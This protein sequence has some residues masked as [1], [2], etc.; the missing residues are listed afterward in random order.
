MNSSTTASWNRLLV[1]GVFRLERSEKRGLSPCFRGTVPFFSERSK[2]CTFSRTTPVCRFCLANCNFRFRPVPSVEG[3]KHPCR[4]A[5]AV[6]LVLRM[7]LAKRGGPAA[8]HSRLWHERCEKTQGVPPI[9]AGKLP[10]WLC[11]SIGILRITQFPRAFPI[12]P[13]SGPTKMLWRPWIFLNSPGAARN[14]CASVWI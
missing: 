10:G 11:I 2:R 1:E 8:L 4:A 3:G 14:D 13:G 7:S 6:T 5:R 12:C 9:W